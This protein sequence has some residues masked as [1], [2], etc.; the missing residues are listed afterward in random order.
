M[1]AP[2]GQT[3]KL[4]KSVGGK[5]EGILETTDAARIRAAAA[6]FGCR[7]SPTFEPG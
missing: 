3:P 6:T 2:K 4:L 5:G 7:Q 1:R